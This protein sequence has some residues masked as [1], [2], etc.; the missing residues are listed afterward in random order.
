MHK[1]ISARLRAGYARFFRRRVS[2]PA[3]GQPQPRRSAK[4][5]HLR[6]ISILLSSVIGGCLVL[7]I[8]ALT[9]TILLLSRGPI[10]V[11]GLRER[12]SA[13]LQSQ[14]AERGHVS[15]GRTFLAHGQHGPTLRIEDFVLNDNQNRPL[16]RAPVA[17]ISMASFAL[18]TGR[19]AIS[20]LEFS[21]LDVKLA[22]L[23]DGTRAFSAGQ[24]DAILLPSSSASASLDPADI[25]AAIFVVAGQDA[26]LLGDMQH[27]GL[28]N[29]QLDVEDRRTGATISFKQLNLSLDRLSFGGVH[30]LA[31]AT[32]EAGP[33][34]IEI[35]A[36]NLNGPMLLLPSVAKPSNGVYGMEIE[37]KNVPVHKVL[38]AAG[39]G[40]Q[41]LTIAMPLSAKLNAAFQPD[42]H[43]TQLGGYFALDAGYLEIDD[44]DAT[45][46][47]VDKISGRLSF[48]PSTRQLM[49]QNMQY[50]AGITHF[51]ANGQI[52][53]D[54]S[55]EGYHLALSG[56]DAVLSPER[57]SEKPILIDN[58]TIAATVPADMKSLHLDSVALKGPEIDAALS[59]NFL[60][61]QDGPA[62][63]GTI[64]A[65][66]SKYRAILRLWPNFLATEVLKWMSEQVN[67][68]QIDRALFKLDL[69]A[70]NLAASKRKEAIDDSAVAGDVTVSGGSITILPGV[71]PLTGIEGALHITG[72]SL[73]FS[74]SKALIEAANHKLNFT[75]A[76]F[77]V[78]DTRPQ[79]LNPA[80]LTAHV[81]GN[82]DSAVDILQRDALRHYNN[83]PGNPS[84]YKG[85]LDGTLDIDMKLGKTAS[86]DDVAVKTNLTT[87]NLSV[88]KVLDS[89]RLET[90]NLVIAT[91][92][93]FMSVKGD[94]RMFGAPVSLEL[95]KTGNAPTD[96]TLNFTIDDATRVKRGFD[97][98][99]GFSG[100]MLIRAVTQ[101]ADGDRPKTDPATAETRAQI[102]IDL[103]K[104]S[105]DGLLPGWTKLAGRPART[106]FTFIQTA[107]GVKLDGFQLDAGNASLRGTVMLGSDMGFE[108]AK[109]SSF[110]LSPQDDLK[111]DIV[112]D[113]SLLKL[114]GRAGTIDARP[115][116][117]DLLA[118]SRAKSADGL[119]YDLDLKSA[120]LIGFNK[121]HIDGLDLKL[122]RHGS[123]LQKSVASGKLGSQLFKITTE[124]SGDQP[125]FTLSADNAGAFLNFLDMYRHMEGGSLSVMFRPS[126]ERTIGNVQIRNF[127]LNGEPAIRPLL[128]QN[129]GAAGNDGADKVHFSR[130]QG[131]F[132]RSDGRIDINDAA[133]WGPQLGAT[134]QGVM[135]YGRDMVDLAGNLI[136]AYQLNN[137][138][139]KIPLFGPLLGGGKNEGLFAINYRIT[140]K[141]SAPLLRVDPL[142]AIAP[143][144]LR[145]IMSVA[146]G[147]QNN[148]N[149][150]APNRPSDSMPGV[151]DLPL[152]PPM[153]L[154]APA[155]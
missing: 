39:V 54:V 96:A 61:T 100:P 102:D 14:F 75:D 80:S 147:T 115:F 104:T 83:I 121:E 70:R 94:G 17:D 53:Q 112:K 113:D 97:F 143:G 22:V 44:P 82:V 107:S 86:P 123:V 67:G 29:G 88:E 45:P 1:P 142:S 35:L 155:Q 114:T 5:L 131:N 60:S 31:G 8:A 153:D 149:N 37:V 154:R 124:D 25:I 15:I 106:A 93:A 129:A 30:M 134:M 55:G 32:G 76:K 92:K 59:M 78:P 85:Q 77:T 84:Q 138:F 122:K 132:D 144:I 51:A 12:I 137:L 4:Y 139:A 56:K 9:V 38:V 27:I 66:K 152:T 68:G 46:I 48:D 11:P 146:D 18:M 2:T 109:F 133:M 118:H 81:Q 19:L 64:T 98:G 63:S 150:L 36:H 90:A 52:V 91:S 58:V 72:T 10:E 20:G 135:D 7:A 151:T 57:S 95:K 41:P 103:S 119:D 43:L 79:K 62:L 47:P 87:S 34:S 33:F 126:L 21:G 6:R 26:P 50:L 74:G 145:K 28:S 42:G 136:P 110:K 111:L 69:D 120:T 49:L 116:I 108:S 125:Q 24:E 127:V 148:P 40:Q 140:G 128:N 73:Q 101:L 16:V 23:P 13:T 117:S 99:A 105:I 3:Y 141:V 71:P 130:L 89:E 65:L